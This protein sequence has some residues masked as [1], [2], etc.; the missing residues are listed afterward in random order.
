[1]EKK[2]SFVRISDDKHKQLSQL[3][4]ASKLSIRQF[5]DYL[6]EQ[7]FERNVRLSVSNSEVEATSTVP[8]QN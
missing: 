5:T 1:M 2:Y 6:I 8:Q 4:S 7:A 3:A